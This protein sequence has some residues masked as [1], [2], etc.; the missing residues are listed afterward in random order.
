MTGNVDLTFFK[1][2]KAKFSAELGTAIIITV[3]SQNIDELKPQVFPDSEFD[4]YHVLMME[5]WNKGREHFI[6][7]HLRESDFYIFYAC[8]EFTWE[9]DLATGKVTD[10]TLDPFKEIDIEKVREE[11]AKLGTILSGNA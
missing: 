4:A 8:Q 5:N 7:N 9:E 3:T 6:I 1:Q 2:V 11:L 10:F